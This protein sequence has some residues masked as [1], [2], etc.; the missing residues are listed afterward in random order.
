[1]NPIMTKSELDEHLQAHWDELG[2]YAKK[3]ISMLA[4]SIP[5]EDAVV[6]A[7]LHC[8]QCREEIEG[9]NE[10]IARSKNWI[11]MNLRWTQSPLRREHRGREHA[12][13]GDWDR[14]QSG[15]PD[16]ERVDPLTALWVKGLGV[17]SR[18][19]WSLY[20]DLDLRRGRALAEHLNISTSGAY[21]LLK[22]ARELEQSYR[23]WILKHLN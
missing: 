8:L 4:L 17:R 12:E 11:K 15:D 14:G 10:F 9:P 18:R 3:Y 7:Y 2:L 1:M 16:W 19:I 20:W 21:L 6:G 22:E 23:E 5:A 13:L